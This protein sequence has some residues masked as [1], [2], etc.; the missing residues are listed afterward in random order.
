MGEVFELST[1]SSD[2]PLELRIDQK[3]FAIKLEMRYINKCYREM[4]LFK[5]GDL[6]VFATKYDPEPFAWIHRAL[7]VLY[8]QK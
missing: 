5:D 4:L 1:N 3:I 2:P 6:E 7:L 8:T